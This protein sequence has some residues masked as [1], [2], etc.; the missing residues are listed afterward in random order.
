MKLDIKFEGLDRLIRKMN[1]V[2]KK[3]DSGIEL[4]DLEIKRIEYENKPLKEVLEDFVMGDN[5]IIYKNGIP[6]ILYI[7]GSYSSVDELKNNPKGPNTP[8]YHIVGCCSTM[9]QMKRQNRYDRYVFD[10]EIDEKFLVFGY[11][12]THKRGWRSFHKGEAI[13]VQDVELGVCINCLKYV[14]YKKINYDYGIKTGIGWKND[15]EVEKW[16]KENVQE[17]F[18][19]PRFSKHSLPKPNYTEEFK[20]KSRKLKEQY[21][22]ICQHSKCGLDLSDL[23]NKRLLHCDHED[24]NVGY[25]AWKNLRILCIDC[26]RYLGIEKTAG[27]EADMNRCIQLKKEKGIKIFSVLNE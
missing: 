6:Y 1:A 23:N 7:K 12:H 9:E 15:F 10:P 27:M 14:N 18:I 21:K 2:E 26:H 19:K 11:P 20:E 4:E 3:W 16:F 22:Y 8:R 24:G 5:G 13:E 17:K 25:N